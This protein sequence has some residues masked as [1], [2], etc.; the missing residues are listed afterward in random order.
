[1]LAR[2]L[3]LM[4]TAAIGALA[5]EVVFGVHLGISGWVHRVFDAGQFRLL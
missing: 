3:A 2:I 5:L 1:M 4:M